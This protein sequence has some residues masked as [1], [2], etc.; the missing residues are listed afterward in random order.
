LFAQDFS[1][2]TACPGMGGGC[3]SGIRSFI[4]WHGEIL[5]HAGRMDGELR[6]AYRSE[7]VA[8]T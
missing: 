5:A 4:G 8:T 7:S 1:N 6:H 3:R 2:I